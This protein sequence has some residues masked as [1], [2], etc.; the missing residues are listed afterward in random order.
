MGLTDPGWQYTT[1]FR[2]KKWKER[3]KLIGCI[4]S[5]YFLASQGIGWGAWS[6]SASGWNVLTVTHSAADILKC[7]HLGW[8]RRCAKKQCFSRNETFLGEIQCVLLRH[9]HIHKTAVWIQTTLFN[10]LITDR[11]FHLNQDFRLCKLLFWHL[12]D[13]GKC[14]LC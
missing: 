1:S 10:C 14:G 3:E 7:T 4:E 9:G 2:W 8:A 13:W 12:K 11:C 5:F 6:D